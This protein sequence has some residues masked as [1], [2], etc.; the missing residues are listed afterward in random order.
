[1]RIGR[2]P[3]A[4][5]RAG[6]VHAR[7]GSGASGAGSMPA[8]GIPGVTLLPASVSVGAGPDAGWVGFLGQA[9][10]AST[11]TPITIR[12]AITR[13]DIRERPLLESTAHGGIRPPG[14]KVP[15]AGAGRPATRHGRRN[16]TPLPGVISGV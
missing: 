14:Q 10:K 2:S 6:T 16:P 8:P 4:V 3:W 11:A 1:M 7:P 12:N 15:E 9:T 5:Q 13:I